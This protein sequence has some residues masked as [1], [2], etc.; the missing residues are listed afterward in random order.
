MK[1]ISNFH[2]YYDVCQKH[3][4]DTRVVYIRHTPDSNVQ[5][6]SFKKKQYPFIW[7][8]VEEFPCNNLY[9]EPSDKNDYTL[10]LKLRFLGFCGKWYPFFHL[11]IQSRSSI[12]YRPDI[13]IYCYSPSSFIEALEKYNFLKYKETLFTKKSKHIYSSQLKYRDIEV[14]F[15]KFSGI[16]DKSNIFVTEKCPVI[17][18]EESSYR[19]TFASEAFTIVT[20]PNLSTID[21]VK[22]V[23]PYT[24]FQELEMYISGVLGIG[25]PQI[26]TISDKDK[27][28]KRGF[29]KWSFRK[30]SVP[31]KEK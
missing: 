27:I 12:N 18:I 9:T 30:Q 16:A 26:V 15:N 21:F 8:M 29:N 11:L 1:I 7:T 19:M 2:D 5:K 28:E 3:G 17:L 14:Y 23:D 4:Q 20:N 24:A 10:D 25:E 6:V 13:N 22:I 31:F